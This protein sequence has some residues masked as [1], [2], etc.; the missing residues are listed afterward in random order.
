MRGRVM[1]ILASAVL[2]GSLLATG[3]QARGGGGGGGHG[4]GGGGHMGGG[5]GGGHMGGGF[6]GGHM[7]GV[8]GGHIGGFGGGHVGGAHMAHVGHEHFGAGRRRFVGGGLAITA[9]GLIARITGLP[10]LGRTPATTERLP[11]RK[12]RRAAFAL[13]G[14]PG[15]IGEQQTPALPGGPTHRRRRLAPSP[16]ERHG[17]SSA[18]QFEFNVLNP[19]L[20]A[21]LRSTPII[22]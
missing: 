16:F 18:L 22:W 12:S 9:T 3:A 2:A 21:P 1:M 13:V 20:M 19:N 7:G 11:T 10:T 17:N 6:G 15:R 14:S 8:G 5:F 4:G